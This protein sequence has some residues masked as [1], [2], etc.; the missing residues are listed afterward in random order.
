MSMISIEKS[1]LIAINAHNGKK[2]LDGN[3]VLL[4]P[5]RVGLQ[6]KNEKEIITGFLHDVVEDSEYTF[7]DLIELGVDG[8]IIEALELLTHDKS[9]DYD[10]YLDRLVASHN[11]LALSVKF[12]DLSDNLSRNDRLTE[13]KEKIYQKHITAIA[14]IKI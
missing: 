8:E 11:K 5:I 12:Y 13:K 2:D 7:N 14:K 4:H 3:P 9:M 10:A 6:G 1:L